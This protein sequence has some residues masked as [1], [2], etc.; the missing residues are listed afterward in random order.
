MATGLVPV[1]SD[2][3][4][5]KDFILDGETGY[6]FDHRGSDAAINL[7]DILA[8]AT[9]NW[10]KTSGIAKQSI[11]MASKFS[12]TQVANQYIAEF[13]SLITSNQ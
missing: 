8:K 5:F 7:S 13:K 9:L 11:H 10:S 2:L 6:C 1:V 12:Y 3:Q 4:C